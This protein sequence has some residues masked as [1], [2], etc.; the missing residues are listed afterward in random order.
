MLV[1]KNKLN[2]WLGFVLLILSIYSG[3]IIGWIT[4]DYGITISFFGVFYSL[5]ILIAP[6]V[7]EEKK[8]E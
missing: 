8:N 7:I 4:E 5:I 3:G 2:F 1:I 6:N